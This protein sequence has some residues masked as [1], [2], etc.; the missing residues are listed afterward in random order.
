MIFFESSFPA[1]T[2]DPT[3]KVVLPS[4]AS[5]FCCL[6]GIF[7]FSSERVKP[8]PA[9]TRRLYLVV[10]HRTMGRSWSTGR[11]ATAAALARRASRLWCFF[12]GYSFETRQSLVHHPRNSPCLHRQNFEI[13]FPFIRRIRFVH[14]K[15]SRVRKNFDIVPGR[16]AC[17][18]DGPSPCGSLYKNIPNQPIDSQ[19]R[20][21]SL[22]RQKFAGSL[23][24]VED[25]VVVLL[26]TTEKKFNQQ[27]RPSTMTD[28]EKSST[29]TSFN[30]STNFEQNPRGQGGGG[31][32]SITHH[33][34]GWWSSPG[35]GRCRRGWLLVVFRYWAELFLVWPP[36]QSR[37]A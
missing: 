24:L 5:V 18:H 17:E 15:E 26:Y 10:G 25:L 16:S 37:F 34:S 9:R 7:T 20:K 3:A 29:Q 8:R 11:G 30:L 28:R 19:S 21:K 2:R 4:T 36:A 27:S 22:R 14:L 33:G 35:V 32:S 23:T 31:G 13:H 6:R 12:A 1:Q